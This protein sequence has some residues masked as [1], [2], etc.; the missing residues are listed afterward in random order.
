MLQVVHAILHFSLSVE[1]LVNQVEHVDTALVDIH[2]LVAPCI[3]G[4][5]DGIVHLLFGLWAMVVG[6]VANLYLLDIEHRRRTILDS[7]VAISHF[8]IALGFHH[9]LLPFAGL[10]IPLSGGTAS[11]DPHTREIDIERSIPVGF[12]IEGY[13]ISGKGINLE[14]FNDVHLCHSANSEC[15]L[16]IILG[17]GGCTTTCGTRISANRLV[18]EVYR[19]AFHEVNGDFDGSRQCIQPVVGLVGI[20]KERTAINLIADFLHM[21]KKVAHIEEVHHTLGVDDRTRHQGCAESNIV[22][23]GNGGSMSQFL[24]IEISHFQQSSER[25]V[26]ICL[27]VDVALHRVQ[28]LIRLY[29]TGIGLSSEIVCLI[30]VSTGSEE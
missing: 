19:L 12:C 11:V 5:I 22:E 3:D 4:I 18:V 13:G 28:V 30:I 17:N 24:L 7:Q 16:I 14:A 8:R 10:D 15:V 20:G 9:N 23:V 26:G 27:P 6:I 2:Q 21:G 1:G 25:H 29:K